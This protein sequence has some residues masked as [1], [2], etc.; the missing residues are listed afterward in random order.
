MPKFPVDQAS[1]RKLR[2]FK[3]KLASD[4]A[5]IDRWIAAQLFRPHVLR[6]DQELELIEPRPQAQYRLGKPRWSRTHYP[7][8][9]K[10]S[11]SPPSKQRARPS[12]RKLSYHEAGHAIAA[13]LLGLDVV[14]IDMTLDVDRGRAATV[15]Y[16]SATSA[17]L[18]SNDQ[19]AL[20]PSL[21]VDVMVQMAGIAAQ[22][23]AGYSAN[24]DEFMSDYKN[25]DI[26]N[27]FRFAD[28]LAR[29]EAGL[30]LQPGPDESPKLPAA[31]RPASVA[32]VNRAEAEI[33]RKL[34]NSWPAVVRVAGLLYRRDRLR[35]VELDRAIARRRRVSC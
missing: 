30:P 14:C 9:G 20:A 2:E 31:L 3:R 24:D 7:R 19:A 18:A 4:S 6:D 35:Q 12:R 21:Y 34:K 25:G 27:A 32:I 1:R 33:T 8:R 23:L 10:P 15:N 17:A 28:A 22:R 29:L 26:D 13:R 16:R 5:A 11:M